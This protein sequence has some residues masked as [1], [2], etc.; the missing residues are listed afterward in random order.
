MQQRKIYTKRLLDYEIGHLVKS[1]C[2]GCGQRPRFPK[3]MADCTALDRVQTI[4][5]Q[6]IS[7]SRAYALWEAH[8][9]LLAPT[10]DK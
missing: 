4:L 3:C 1:P 9:L 2:R 6:S 5:A 10:E 7:T 8:R